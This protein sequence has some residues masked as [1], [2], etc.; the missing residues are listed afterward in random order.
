MCGT[1][2]PFLYKHKRK[3]LYFGVSTHSIRYSSFCA[4]LYMKVHNAF[5]A[6]QKQ[7][8]FFL[9]TD[10][11]VQKCRKKN[12][13]KMKTW[14]KSVRKPMC[15]QLLQTLAKANTDKSGIYSRSAFTSTKAVE[16]R[17]CLWCVSGSVCS[18]G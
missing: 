3:A 4:L 16:T 10:T 8:V 9:Y 17:R 14:L 2:P 18:Y 5:S 7:C 6:L 11:F 13:K 15:F 1:L 12:R